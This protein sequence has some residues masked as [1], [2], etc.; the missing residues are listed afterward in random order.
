MSESSTNVDS[1]RSLKEA[2]PFRPYKITLNNGEELVVRRRSGIGI[3]PEGRYLVYPTDDG[4]YRI[5]RPQEIR[6]AEAVEG[7]AA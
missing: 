7:S 6:S 2:D 3:S 4:G 5:V 1:I